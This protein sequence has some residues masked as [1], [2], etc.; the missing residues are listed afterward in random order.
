[1]LKHDFDATT[2][3]MGTNCKKWDTYGEDVIPM[4]IADTD[5][6][7]PQ[8]VL[9]AIRTRAEHDIYGYPCINSSY[10]KAIAGWQSRRFGWNVEPEWVEYTPAVVPAIVYAMRAFTNPGDSVVVMMPA[11]HPFHSVIPHSGRFIAPNPLIHNE[12]KGIWEID[13]ENFE[14]LL[15][16]P[17]T[18]MFLLCNPHNPTGRVFT[19][20]ELERM[21]SLCKKHHVFVVS[22]EIHSDI[23]YKG[24]EHIPFG[25]VNEDAANNCV[26]CV[27]PSKTFNIA[28]F[29]TGAAIIPNRNNHDLFYAELENLKAYGRNIFGTLAVETAY[30]QCD[31]YADQLMEYLQGNLEY[32]KSFLEERV[33]EMKMGEVQATYL[34]W[35]DCRALGMDHKVMMDFFLKEAKVALNDGYTFGPGGD[36]FMRLNIACPRAQLVEALNRI[37]VAIKKIRK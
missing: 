2:N 3:R 28:G 37:E 5:F 17:R 27:N 14:S 23:V 33:P 13:W 18:T 36:G 31:Y 16:Q 15:A 10:E 25:S 19:R 9:D 11:Y 34:I 4:W 6:K 12:E 7:C 29:R 8:P 1:M 26:V 32:L 24:Y 20:E 30:S 22:D 35:L 21:A